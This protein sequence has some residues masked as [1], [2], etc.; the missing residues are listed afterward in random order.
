MT[1]Q[2]QED[3]TWAIDKLNTQID[4]M[5]AQSKTLKGETARLE[6]ELGALARNQ[7]EMGK[8]RQE[9]KSVYAK[10]KPELEQGLSGV[11]NALKV[12]R[13]YYAQDS[14]NSGS[15]DGTAGGIIGMLEVVESDFSKGLAEMQSTEE[16]AAAEYQEATQENEVAKAEKT[17]DAKY[18]KAEYVGLD[19][20]IAELRSDKSGATTELNAVNEYMRSIEKECVAKPDSYEERKKRRDAEMAGLREALDT[21]GGE[22]MFLQ[23][24][25][26]RTL[27]GARHVQV[28]TM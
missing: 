15:A 20:T 17:Q 27:R 8:L 14:T 5:V 6:K 26:H 18:K 1:K 16:S 3:K 19:K 25:S 7:A 22:A 4:V 9:E 21:L 23:V 11:K 2:S 13:D 10:N 24:Q 28:G 12:L